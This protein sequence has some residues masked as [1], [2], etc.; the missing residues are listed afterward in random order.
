[1]FHRCTLIH[2][3][4]IIIF[5]ILSCCDCSSLRSSTNDRNLNAHDG[6]YKSI[7]SLDKYGSS[8]QINNARIA[9]Q[10]YGLP[11]VIAIASN[12]EETDLGS[13]KENQSIQSEE[14]IVVVSLEKRRP[15]VKV[16]GDKGAVINDVPL[17]RATKLQLIG[18]EHGQTSIAILG[19]G[20]KADL[21]FI[22]N[23]LRRHATRLWERY[24]ILPDSNRIAL[25]ASQIM[26]AFMGYSVDDEIQDGVDHIL[27]DE[28]DGKMMTVGRPLTTS[29]VVCEVGHHGADIKALDPSGLTLES[30]YAWALGRGSEKS[31]ELLKKKLKPGLTVKAVQ[32]LCMDIIH[33]VSLEE[34]L[35]ASSDNCEDDGHLKEESSFGCEVL[36]RQG[37][38]YSRIPF[39][40]NR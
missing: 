40:V 31:R 1:M 19:S 23:L 26:L 32:D 34:N 25:A 22:A 39:R 21:T 7:S 10:R 35:V 11:T 8:P 9:S 18:R 3:A 36:S 12:L 16:Y 2:L 15:G 30:T 20:L 27:T 37:L 17:G 5:A 29:L 14:V 24:D 13:A 4:I 33:E 6:A 38:S 28:S